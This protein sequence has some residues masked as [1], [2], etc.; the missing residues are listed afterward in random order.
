M[1]KARELADV[2]GTQS[3]TEN[4]LQGRRNLIINGAMQVAQ[5]G[6][7]AV[8][9]ST[10]YP[11]DRFSIHNATDGSFSG[12]QSSEAPAGFL[13]SIKY[14]TT[15]PDASLGSTQYAFIITSLEGINTAHL[16]WGTNDAKNVTLSFWVRS[17]LTATFGGALV[18]GINTI[19]YPF[20]YT[21]SSANTWQKIEISVNG[22]TSG[23]WATDKSIGIKV[24]FGLGVG[25][26]YS[27][28]S[29]QWAS[30]LYL[31]STDATSVIGTDDATFYI[32]GVQLE[33]G[34]VAT[35]FEHRSYG[36]EL[37]LCQRYYR[38]FN[39]VSN[40]SYRYFGNT[41]STGASAVNIALSPEMRALPTVTVGGTNASSVDLSSYNSR[42][43][44]WLFSNTTDAVW[45]SDIKA[46][47][48][49]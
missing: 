5:R 27:G 16:S 19:S 26:T 28:T 13:N 24:V 9:G 45:F 20:S 1:T 30:T 8:T 42:D 7:S 48:E 21:I 2:I 41:Y 10:D 22:E 25:S 35:P 17:S 11:V 47:A 4:V 32:T 18:N 14:T 23:T 46:D 31:S 36:E 12:V 15:S 29:G 43:R 6:A 39:S 3:T 33:V 34:S 37:A 40:S 44:L 38:R 49:L